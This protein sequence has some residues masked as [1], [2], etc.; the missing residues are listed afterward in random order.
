MGPIHAKNEAIVHKAEEGGYWVE[1]PASPGCLTR[2]ETSA[3]L[4]RNLQEAVD[5]YLS[6]TP[7]GRSSSSRPA[8]RRP[9][10]R[11]KARA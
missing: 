10:A 8:K 2:A 7:V 5:L 9:A 1:V 11:R 6:T 4:R 3:E